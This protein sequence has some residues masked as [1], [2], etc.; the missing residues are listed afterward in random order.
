MKKGRKF[1]YT[2]GYPGE[3]LRNRNLYEPR[4][5]HPEIKVENCSSTKIPT[6]GC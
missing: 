3:K 5:H 2:G 6:V 1:W 4:M